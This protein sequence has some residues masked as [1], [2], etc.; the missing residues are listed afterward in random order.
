MREYDEKRAYEYQDGEQHTDHQPIAGHLDIDCFYDQEDG[1]AEYSKY[2]TCF[3]HDLDALC[4]GAFGK[5]EAEHSSPPVRHR[6]LDKPT[7]SNSVGSVF[8]SS[9]FK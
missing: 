9:S 8:S 4:F 3:G 2:C 7:S 5:S 6:M 1:N